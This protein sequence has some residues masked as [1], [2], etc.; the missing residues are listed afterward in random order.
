LHRSPAS[1]DDET[2]E[3]KRPDKVLFPDDGY[4]K[5]DLAAYYDGVAKWMLPYLADRP[6][7]VERYPDGID[8]PS[9]FEKNVSRHAPAWIKT[10]E[11]A[12]GGKRESVRYM[13]CDERRTLAYLA[14]LAAITLH[15]WTSRVESLDEP[16]YVFFD[17]D[18]GERCP[19]AR[20][21]E[22]ALKLRS[23]LETI[24]LKTLV[25][26]S[27][28][29]G[30]HVLVPLRPEYDYPLVRTFGEVVA[31][32]L[33]DVMPKE[34][35]LERSTS[36][37]PASAVYFDYVQIGRGKT[38]VAPYT[39]RARPGAPVSMPLAW[40]AVQKMTSSR[41]S[42]AHKHFQ[43]WSIKTVPALLRRSG[44]PWKGAFSHPQGL[45]R[46]IKASRTKW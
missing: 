26:S 4:T 6:L 37:R 15:V 18:P 39:V 25:K 14:N 36:K 31:R 9:F 40:S 21:A 42:S 45:E 7:S 41:S 44:D 17:L 16:D 43:T 12:G 5:A 11:I 10:V 22:V 38:M 27:G 3:L 19:L 35:T 33:A 30:L 1:G 32:K 8:G 23:L 28:G 13:V 46:A 34:V 29:S 24:G 2:V 20:L